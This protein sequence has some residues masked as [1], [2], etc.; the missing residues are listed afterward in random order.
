MVRGA[1]AALLGLEDDLLVVGEAA[2]GR[3]AAA[4]ASRA[5]PDVVLL[6]VEMPGLDG[7]AAAP[8]ILSAAPGCKI[9]ML[10]AGRP[11]DLDRAMEAGASAFLAKDGPAPEIAAA[12]RR[13]VAGE[14]VVDSTLAL[15]PAGRPETHRGDSA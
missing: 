12:I 11:G 10:A 5:R 14:R 6:D 4:L 3:E 8:G 15:R 7:P 2:G 1:L 13:V 9:V